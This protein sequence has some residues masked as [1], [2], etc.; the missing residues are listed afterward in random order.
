MGYEAR[1][2][3]HRGDCRA[4]APIGR[5]SLPRRR[6]LRVDRDI[7]RHVE[8]VIVNLLSFSPIEAPS[9]APTSQDPFRHPNNVK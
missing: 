8:P 7:A 3:I 9:G 4:A 2:A 5:T 1:A 6:A